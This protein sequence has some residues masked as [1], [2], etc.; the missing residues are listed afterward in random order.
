VGITFVKAQRDNRHPAATYVL[1]GNV[2]CP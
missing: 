2:T 1:A